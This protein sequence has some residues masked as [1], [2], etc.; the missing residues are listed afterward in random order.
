MLLIPTV[1][2]KANFANEHITVAIQEDVQLRMSL[3]DSINL[4]Q[5]VMREARDAIQTSRFVE[6]EE[7]AII[8]FPFQAAR[9]AQA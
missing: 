2:P 1:A 8:A 4:A 9:R 7:C 5:S 6:P 3:H